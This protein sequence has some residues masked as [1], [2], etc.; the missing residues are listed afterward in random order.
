MTR[1]IAILAAAA[2]LIGLGVGAFFVLRGQRADRFAD[3][4]DGMVTGTAAIGGP[5]TLT[6][7]NGAT[8][9][10]TEAITRPTLVYF[11]YTY[12]PDF[13]PTDLA[14]NAAAADLLAEEG[15]DVGQVFITTDPE[16]DTGEVVRDFAAAIHPDLLGLTGTPQQLR[17]AAQAYKVYARKSGDDPEFYMMDHSTFTYLMAPEVGFLEVYRSD[18]RPQALAES[19]SCFVAAL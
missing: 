14:R 18:V 10:E 19:A 5:F 1:V 9:T 15:V 2:V 4:R 8:V 3:C 11:G 17:S 16:R 12:C 7:G 13:C 6:D